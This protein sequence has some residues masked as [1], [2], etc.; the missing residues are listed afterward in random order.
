[1]KQLS[2]RE[3][4]R[5]EKLLKEMKQGPYEYWDQPGND[6]LVAECHNKEEGKPIAAL[7]GIMGMKAEFTAIAALLN[8]APALIAMARQAS[9]QPDSHA[10]QG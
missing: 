8:A 10:G 7:P 1:M 3:L 5:L 6:F 2:K 4:R 9:A